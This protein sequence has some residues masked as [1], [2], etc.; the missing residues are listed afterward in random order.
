MKIFI[1]VTKKCPSVQNYSFRVSVKKM[2]IFFFDESKI[3][4][5]KGMI[6][7]TEQLIERYFLKKRFHPCK[8]KS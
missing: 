3:I 5:E 6:Q 8:I 7:K 2:K 1:F 4:Q